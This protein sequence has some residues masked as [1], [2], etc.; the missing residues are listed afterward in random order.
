MMTNQNTK[1]FTMT[2]ILAV[3]GIMSL[4]TGILITYSRTGERQILLFREQAKIINVV[5]R[6]KSLALN[7]YIEEG[8]PCAYGVHFDP[9]L[10]EIRI[11]RDLDA[12]GQTDDC[13][14]T[15]P[16]LKPDNI[17]TPSAF[18][19]NPEDLNPPVVEKLDAILSFS[20]PI[21]ITDIVFIPPNPDTIITPDPAPSNE[22]SIEII[23]LDGSFKKI[24][25]NNFGQVTVE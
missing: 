20:E 1:G 15:D 14:S 24:K 23:S 22:G 18:S 13:D 19:P 5:L 12:N 6:A 8:S 10:K 25:I 4:L 16:G 7:T 17:Y 3:L 21:G 11:L 9:A 2:E